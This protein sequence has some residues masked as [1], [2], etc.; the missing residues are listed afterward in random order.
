MLIMYERMFFVRVYGDIDGVLNQ[1]EFGALCRALFRNEKGKPYPVDTADLITLFTIFDTNK[2]NAI[3]KEEFKFCWQKWIKQV[4]PPINRL[5]EEVN[6]DVVVY[7]LD[8]H[9]PDHVSFIDNIHIRPLHQ[10]CKIS[11]EDAR[12]YDVLTFDIQHRKQ[13]QKMWPRH[14][15]QNTWGSELHKDLKVSEDAVLVKKGTDPDVDSYSA[16]WDNN[17]LSYT[18]LNEE[19]Q[20]RNIT[21]V[22][23]CGIAY[24]V[25]VGA[26]ATHANEAGYRTI[27]IEDACRG[28]SEEDIRA[29]KEAIKANNGLIIQS[30][31]VKYLVNGKDRPPQLGMKLALELASKMK[32]TTATTTITTTTTTT[33]TINNTANSSITNATGKI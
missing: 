33:A 11:S 22:F 23:V 19:L 21:D 20:K 25:C 28:V 16:F 12:V 26:T 8:W 17:K 14:C 30:S 9:P 27:L 10:S 15:V 2:D 5:V 18:S 3:N 29:T 4:I 1:T 7:S 13:D 31:K 6:F 32:K 24:D